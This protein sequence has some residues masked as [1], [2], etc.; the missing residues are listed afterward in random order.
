MTQTKITQKMY[1]NALK[2]FIGEGEQITLDG[3]TY[4]DVM[5]TE[6]INSQIDKL[7]KKNSHKSKADK[8]K[9]LLNEKIRNEIVSYLTGIEEPVGA[10][11]LS[12]VLSDRVG[13][14]VSSQRVTPQLTKLVADE[15]V[16]KMTEKGKTFY[17]IA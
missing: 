14:F 13:E 8:E 12:M 4:T 10:T 2:N 17:K 5:L 1:F 6:F 7:D 3:V 15:M 9:D 16:V 11:Q